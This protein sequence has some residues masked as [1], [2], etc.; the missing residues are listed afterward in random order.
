MPDKWRIVPVCIISRGSYCFDRIV[1]M[2]PNVST[3]H[4]GC[5]VQRTLRKWTSGDFEQIRSFIRYSLQLV[6]GM[7][8]Y[9]SDSAFPIL[10]LSIPS[11]SIFIFSTSIDIYFFNIYNI[12]KITKIFFAYRKEI[13]DDQTQTKY[14]NVVS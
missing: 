12:V 11:R 2:S 7:T 14:Y 4:A 10:S 8:F 6:R 1:P 9:F 13:F 3:W 5:K